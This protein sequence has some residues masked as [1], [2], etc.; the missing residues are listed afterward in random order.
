MFRIPGKGK[1]LMKFWWRFLILLAFL[2]TMGTAG[3]SRNVTDR[4]EYLTQ[5]QGL[6]QS[7]VYCIYQDRMGFI[8]FGTRN[9]LNRYD[10]T[11]FVVYKH[12]RLNRNSLSN[13]TIRSICG[14][15]SGNLWIGTWGGGVNRFEAKTGRFARFPPDGDR[16]PGAPEN[17]VHQVMLDSRN[18]LWVVSSAGLSLHCLDAGLGLIGFTKP[19][20]GGRLILSGKMFSII[21]DHQHTIWVGSGDGLQMFDEREQRFSQYS[22]KDSWRRRGKGNAVRVVFEDDRRQL[23]L[24]MESGEVYLF[25]RGK[26]RFEPWRVKGKAISDSLRLDGISRIYQDLFGDVW[27]GTLSRGVVKLSRDSGMIVHYTHDPN[28]PECINDNR[29]KSIFMDRSASL[30][31]GTDSGL[32]KCSRYRNKF[33]LYRHNPGRSGV[34]VNHRVRSISEDAGGRLLLGMEDGL[35]RL[36]ANR[37]GVSRYRADVFSR[38]AE[39]GRI[40]NTIMRDV[41]GDLWLGTNGGLLVLHADGP[42]YSRFRNSPGDPRSLVN[43]KVWAIHELDGNTLLIG[44]MGGLARFDK[45]R[46]Y[47]ENFTHDADNPDSLC[48]NYVHAITGDHYGGLWIGTDAGLD[49]FDVKH[50]RFRHYLR[51]P[52]SFH[53]PGNNNVWA[54]HESAE[55][56]LYAGT[57]AGLTRYDRDRDCFELC[58]AASPLSRRAIYGLLEDGD[59]KLWISTDF[60][61]YRF[62]PL[63]RRLR[64]YDIN[65]G[66]QGNEFGLGCCFKSGSGELF[67]GGNDGFNGFFPGDAA[68][69]PSIP[70]VVITDVQVF[71]ASVKLSGGS[72]SLH[73]TAPA[74]SISL[75]HKDDFLGFYFAALDY[76]IPTKN[77]YAYILEGFQKEWRYCGTENHAVFTNL[78]YGKYVFRVKGSNHDGIWNQAGASL[79][80]HIRPPFWATWWFRAAGMLMLFLLVSLLMIARERNIRRRAVLDEKVNQLVMSQKMRLVGLLAAGATHDLSNILFTIIRYS[81]KLKS[82]GTGGDTN[83]YAGQLK[84]AAEKAIHIVKQILAFS[85]PGQLSDDSHDLSALIDEVVGILGATIPAGIDL[86]W[87]KA[88]EPLRMRV[89]PIRFQQMMMNLIYNAV[90]A[91]PRGGAI[92]IRAVREGGNTILITVDDDGKGMDSGTIK[93]IFN[94]Y[95]STKEQAGNSGLGLFVVRR[96]VDDYRGRIRVDSQPGK[97]TRFRISFPAG[98]Q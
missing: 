74:E 44:T 48:C 88:D 89:D 60:G 36:D 73:R 65:D 61:L 26:K 92:R 84:Q 81:N 87:E 4:F 90:E 75:S 18:R 51:N 86:Q 91:M 85:R 10:G 42:G 53:G 72:L 52:Q 15:A 32:N 33:K 94:P 43:D 80:L 39:E 40:V 34:T 67:F 13:N 79:A 31:I 77:Q 54:I 83:G 17:F 8:W 9:G 35:I 82:D 78:P 76:T 49:R 14:D 19:G 63:Y 93:K 24:G 68:D 56:E 95:F 1:P 50:R 23:W 97:G 27:I 37:A 3:P 25:S 29:I 58:P 69:N 30:W 59:G 38:I 47:F 57:L 71:G 21:E 20:C 45:S 11:G 41:R 55:G 64:H 98:S 96:I 2:P 16:N 66:L 28:N 12:D 22:A 5:S 7:I 62:D 6:S 70:A 46:G